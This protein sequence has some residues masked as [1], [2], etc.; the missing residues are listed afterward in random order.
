MALDRAKIIIFSEEI[1]MKFNFVSQNFDMDDKI[2]DFAMDKIKNHIGR[3]LT[4]ECQIN[5]RF[6]EIGFEKK[7]EVTMYLNLKKRIVHAEA[8]SDQNMRAA[9]DEVVDILRK[10]MRR[11]KERLNRLSK[12][13]SSFVEESN[14]S[15]VADESDNNLGEETVVN[16]ERIKSFAVKPM[17]PEE[18]VM[19]LELIG[20]SFYVFLNS[21]TNEVN[22]VYKRKNGSYGLIEPKI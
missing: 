6:V 7:V 10:Q 16:I 11:Y 21:L 9:I 5:V 13:N 14:L 8:T 15:F 3:L 2:K 17:D 1:M 18:A 20:H 4:G 19:E 22:V 12:K